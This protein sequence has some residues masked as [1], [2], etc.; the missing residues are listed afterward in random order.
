MSAQQKQA[1]TTLYTTVAFKRLSVDQTLE[2]GD[3]ILHTRLGSDDRLECTV[4]DLGTS[5]AKGDWFLVSYA[6]NPDIEVELSDWEMSEILAHRIT[7][8]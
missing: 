5:R 4:V 1:P 7:A 3:I 6:D 8:P 2:L